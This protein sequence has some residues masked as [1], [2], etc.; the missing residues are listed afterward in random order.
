MSRARPYSCRS[1]FS[2]T[3]SALDLNLD[4]CIHTGNLTTVHRTHDM[5]LQ[6]CDG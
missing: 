1:K 4:L 2:A 3:S 5:D 6:L